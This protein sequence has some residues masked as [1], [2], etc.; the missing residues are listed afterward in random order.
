MIKSIII[1][2][3]LSMFGYAVWDY[4][5]TKMENHERRIAELEATA[6][7]LIIVDKFSRV[8]VGGYDV[9]PEEGE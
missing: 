8:F 6:R 2:L 4:T 1:W 5:F 7:P 3:V 9:T